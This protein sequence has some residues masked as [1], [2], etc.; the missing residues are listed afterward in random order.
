VSLVLDPKVSSKVLGR[1]ISLKDFVMMVNTNDLP[2]TNVQL[3][4]ASIFESLSFDKSVTARGI[5]TNIF[6]FVKDDSISRFV[7][8]P[9]LAGFTSR[10]VDDSFSEFSDLSPGSSVRSTV[11]N[12]ISVEDLTLSVEIKE[13][14]VQ[15]ASGL[16]S[17]SDVREL[18]PACSSEFVLGVSFDSISEHVVL[19]HS[20]DETVGTVSNVRDWW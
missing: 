14:S 9:D 5:S 15:S 2:D 16:S 4:E 18:G 19:S 7:K 8:N 1:R 3:N 10:D 13:L 11:A 6:R 12:A 20:V 17:I